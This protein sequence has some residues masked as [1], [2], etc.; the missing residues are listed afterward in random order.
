MRMMSKAAPVSSSGLA[1]RPGVAGH[2]WRWL[3]L[4]ACV[5]VGWAAQPAAAQFGMGFGGDWSQ[6][7]IAR[8]SATKYADLL[9]FGADQRETALA[10]HEAYLDD[11]KRAADAVQSAI[12]EL[13]QEMQ[14]SGDMETQMA[15]MGRIMQ[16][17]MERSL[18][19]ERNFMSDLRALAFEPGQE[20]R[21]VRVERARR[22]EMAGMMG[23]LSGS[24][25]DLADLARSLELSLHGAAG[26]Q[27]LAYEAEI[28]QAHKPLID[29]MFEF[30]R[31]QTQQMIEGMDFEFDPE[32]TSQ[33][34]RRWERIRELANKARETN[35]RYAEKVAAVL[36]EDDRARWTREVKVRT[37]PSVYR[38]SEPQRLFEKAAGF[39]DL[40]PEQRESL[41]ALRDAYHRQAEPI[42]AKWAEAIT[43]RET[44]HGMMSQWM[45]FGQDE[46]DPVAKAKA[47][48]EAIDQRFAERLRSM[49]TPAQVER[50]PS[51]AGAAFDIEAF[52]RKMGGG[53]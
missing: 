3:C 4:A 2:A 25:V 26:E 10:L 49:L 13:G 14:R 1:V 29:E 31:Q 48:R 27:L 24:G 51:D 52:R 17:F 33:W 44:E 18:E 38:P 9:G 35:A 40:T 21:F 41:A 12:T 30:S 37:W 47:E 19:L 16:A 20:D 53:G 43:A 42:N 7:A 34:E 45:S 6:M 8:E 23:M 39:E 15:T 50:L 5:L 36:T 28:D 46:E 22:R 11:Y 32:Q